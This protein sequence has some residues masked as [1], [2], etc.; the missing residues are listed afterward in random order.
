MTISLEAYFASKPHTQAQTDA[1]V[2]LLQRVNALCDYLNYEPLR[3]PNT[4]TQ[5]SGS[6][7]GQGDGGFRLVTATTGKE[8]SSHKEA[9]GVD[10]YD[11]DEM[12][13]AVVTDAALERF[14][15]YREDPRDTPG[16]AHFTTRAPASG[17]RTFLA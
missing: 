8:H 10:V 17:H 7:A 9:R 12:L 3:C 11:P 2:D 14:G 15:L 5:I 4:G 1:A 13:D 16:W 6:K